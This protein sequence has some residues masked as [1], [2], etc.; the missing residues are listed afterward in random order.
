MTFKDTGFAL[1]LSLETND[2]SAI[3]KLRAML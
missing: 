1:I 2:L 3:I